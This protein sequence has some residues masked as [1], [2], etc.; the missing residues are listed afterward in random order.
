VAKTLGEIASLRPQL[1]ACP[2]PTAEAALL[3]DWDSGYYAIMTDRPHMEHMAEMHASLS[4]L[5]IHTDFLSNRPDLDFSAY[6]LLVLPQVEFVEEAL[7]RKLHAFVESGGMLLATPRLGTLGPNGKYLTTPMPGGLTGLFGITVRERWDLDAGRDDTDAFRPGKSSQPPTVAAGFSLPGDDEIEVC[8]MGHMEM[9]ECL[10]ETRELG[11]YV[12]GAFAE[13]PVLTAH[14]HGQGQ[15]LY[16]ACVLDEA[17]LR[18][19]MRHAAQLSGLEMW[20]DKPDRVDVLQR[21]SLRF[22]LNHCREAARVPRRGP[23]NVLL[24][25]A[26]DSDVHLAP[27][28]VCVIDEDR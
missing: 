7:A 17:G 19:A 28:D 10:P 8:G 13:A 3:F 27:F 9:L 22:Y 4:R 24:G 25:Q 5:G 14:S 21:G 12:G 16:L 26:D 1:E 11:R 20:P 6:R 18:A 15:A 2:L 23:G